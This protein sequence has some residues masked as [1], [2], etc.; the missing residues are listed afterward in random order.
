MTHTKIDVDYIQWL[1]NGEQK[2]VPFYVEGEF[3]IDGDEYTDS[4]AEL[5]LMIVN[6]YDEI[7]RHEHKAEAIDVYNLK[8]KYGIQLFDTEAILL[9]DYVVMYP[10]GITVMSRKYYHVV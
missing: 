6:A 5:A 1:D 8:L 9:S 7:M 3:P 2:N 10:N 4:D